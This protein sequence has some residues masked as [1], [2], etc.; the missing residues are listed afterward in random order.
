V[1]NS[2]CDSDKAKLAPLTVFALSQPSQLHMVYGRRS[3]PTTSMKFLATKLRLCELRTR[4]QNSLLKFRL[5][6]KCIALAVN[7]R[8]FHGGPRPGWHLPLFDA[9]KK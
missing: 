1:H 9:R 4:S 6:R 7:A 3:G 8:S 5:A 2:L